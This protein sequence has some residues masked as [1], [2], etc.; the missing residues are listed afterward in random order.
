[1]I[2]TIGKPPDRPQPDDNAASPD[3]TEPYN[4]LG[5]NSPGE[6]GLSPDEVD[7]GHEV[8]EEMSSRDPEG[9]YRAICGIVLNELA[10]QR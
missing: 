5:D 10:K 6:T 3:G 1:M 9:V 7:M 8:L 4:E 2:I